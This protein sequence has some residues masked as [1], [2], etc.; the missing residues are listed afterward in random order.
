MAAADKSEMFMMF[1]DA[2]GRTI[3][4][5]S[6]ADL[7]A[8]ERGSNALTENFAEGKFFEIDSFTFEIEVP[9]PDEAHKSPEEQA[10][11]AGEW[12]AH[13]FQG[14]TQGATGAAQRGARKGGKKP[15][16]NKGDQVLQP[17]TFKRK[18]DISS[19]T[20]LRTMLHCHGYKSAHMIKRRAAGGK[21]A[22]AVFLRI[23]FEEVL[24]TSIKWS[25]DDQVGETYS[26]ICCKA[27]VRYR[28]QL[29]NGTL[30][31]PASFE[32]TV[33]R[34]KFTR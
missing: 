22:G 33:D 29:P 25:D 15:K 27:G 34:S 4:A 9:N 14:Q 16:S 17:V 19:T 12:A 2:K 18:V 28:P 1:V 11:A 26:F 10:R 13:Q 7:K 8:G 21:V 24:V 23:D 30:G 3:D 31:A 5:E 6:R 20:M 32:W